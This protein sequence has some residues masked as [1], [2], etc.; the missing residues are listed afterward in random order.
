LPGHEIE[1]DVSYGIRGAGIDRIRL[2][3]ISERQSTGMF[4]LLYAL[5]VGLGLRLL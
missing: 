4:G 2:P 5:A 1:Q 3:T